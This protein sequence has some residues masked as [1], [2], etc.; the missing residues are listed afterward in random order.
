MRALGG[1]ATT[2]WGVR[3]LIMLGVVGLL[4]AGL[5]A[6]QAT[7]AGAQARGAELPPYLAD[8][9]DPAVT[10]LASDLGISIREAQQR[11]SGQEPA[12]QLGE[13]L[14]QTLGDRFGGLWFDEAG[15]GRVKVGVVGGDTAGAEALIAGRKLTAVTDLVAVRHSYGELEQ[16]HAW[17]SG[18]I[19]NANPPTANGEIIG[20]ASALLVDKNEVELQL[21]HGQALNAAQQAAVGAAKRRLGAM[22]SLGAWSGKADT[23]ACRWD[24]SFPTWDCDP[25]LRGGMG[26]H[27]RQSGRPTSFCTAGF[28]V[29]SN[30]DHKWFVMTAGHCGA[31]DNT[32]WFSFPVDIGW[33]HC[34]DALI[35]PMHNSRYTQSPTMTIL[36]S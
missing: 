18:M 21:P 20:L 19:I 25:P 23:E 7:A 16:A 17:L 8:A 9:A 26:I 15:G 29:R 30:S 27:R 24:L 31:E 5:L 36:A 13:E 22:L 12:M 28:N 2:R 35:G 3:R 10:T 32:D 34:W 11:I 6:S 33:C 1:L 14:Q 4:L